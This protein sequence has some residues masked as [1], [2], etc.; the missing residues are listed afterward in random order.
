MPIE[1]ITVTLTSCGRIDLLKRTIT[2]FLE[3][4][5][6]PIYEYIVIND[7]P[8]SK[9]LV[10]EVFANLGNCR[11]IHNPV[12]IG[13]KKSLD[14]LFNSVTTNYIFHLEDDWFFEHKNAYV[15]DSLTI[16]ENS[17]DIHQVWVRHS[18]DTPHPAHTTLLTCNGVEYFELHN[19]F[20]GIWNGYSWNP[21]LRRKSDY[22]QMFPNG[23][24]EFNSESECALHSRKFDYKVVQLKNTTCYH[25]GYDRTTYPDG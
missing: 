25:I 9:D 21:G 17:P 8:S 20:N 11:I 24:A 19:N 5:T 16:L 2:S 12:N 4:N 15:L 6:Y 18:H 13:L 1:N 14:I 7:D 23:V 10:E 22:L 3:T